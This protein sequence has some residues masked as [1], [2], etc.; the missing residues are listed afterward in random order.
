MKPSLPQANNLAP[1]H[2]SM[3]AFPL[4][5]LIQSSLVPQRASQMVRFHHRLNRGGQHIMICYRKTYLLDIM[6]PGNTS[7]SLELEAPF[8][9]GYPAPMRVS[10]T[11]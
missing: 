2:G 11:Q 1:R 5:F 6:T 4:R 9:D 8:V 3:A 7:R 10:L